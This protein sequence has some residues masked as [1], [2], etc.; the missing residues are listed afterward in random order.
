MST[1]RNE[2]CPCGSGKKYKRCCGVSA[3]PKLTTPH[4]QQAQAPALENA[5][6]GMDQE[7]MLKFSQ[8]MR[9]LPKGQMQRLQAIMQKAMAGKDI[10][11]EAAEFEKTLPV[12]LQGLLQSAP[13]PE[14]G[15][16][17]VPPEKKESKFS[18]LWKGITGKK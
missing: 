17:Y 11:Q 6:G 13:V 14:G 5:M 2:P 1:G 3:E 9:K 10:S 15:G 8:A 18:K 4:Q 7:W 12:E 16:A